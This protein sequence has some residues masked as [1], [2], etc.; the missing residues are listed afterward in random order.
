MA[1]E[2]RRRQGISMRASVALAAFIVAT[3]GWTS[4]SA[5]QQTWEF[6]GVVGSAPLFNLQVLV[7]GAG[8]FEVASVP[9]PGGGTFAVTNG[10]MIGTNVLGAVPPGA[11]NNLSATAT[12][13]GTLDAPFPA[14]TRFSG[15]AITFP[16]GTVATVTGRRR[17]ES[18][19][20]ERNPANVALRLGSVALLTTATQNR[21]I[22]LR[23]NSLRSGL[24]GGVNLAGLSV[25]ANGQSV[26]VG[27]VLTGL[28]SGG[29]ASADSERAFG[30]LGIF[31]NGQGS[32]GNQTANDREP[33]F[34]FHTAGMTMGA[35]YRFTDQIILGA[36]F[37]YLRTKIDPVVA[38]SDSSIN[39]YSVSLYG[40][41]YIKD[42][43][44][45]DS[46]LTYGRNDYHI[47]RQA[48]SLSGASVD[49][50]TASTDG[51]QFSAS[52]AGGYDFT[53]G[54]LTLGPTGRVTYIRVHIDGFTESGPVGS[55]AARIPQ[56]T[57]ESLTTA[58]GGQAT[59]A[60][61]T[62]WA[63]LLPLVK[64][65]WEHEFKNS[66]RSLTAS[67]LSRPDLLVSAQ[68]GAP[69]RDYFNVGGGVSA[70]FPGGIS[71]FVHFEETLGRANFTNH[72]FTGGVRFE[73]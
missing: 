43:F 18:E 9:C 2:R 45:V 34:D 7:S 72:S 24:G 28:L 42:Q 25:T 10:H 27:G 48:V 32:F 39:G 58:F 41:Y 68:T 46:I 52:A 29:G 22:G 54:A 8:T 57:V 62:S 61:N 4:V 20:S 50:V 36:A 37:G 55:T 69:D 51:D 1:S 66:N 5:A 16:G 3:L 67:L 26:P 60:I 6:V 47:D 63:V 49:R 70:T 71:A 23:M 40:T 19:V 31:A 21:N 30:R 73:F 13:A 59:Y 64:A 53:A 44:Y 38:L 35:D 11:C 15:L 14:A 17:L 33:G 56:Q 12:A 65:E